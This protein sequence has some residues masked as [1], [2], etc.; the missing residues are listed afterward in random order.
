[1]RHAAQL[2]MF[3]TGNTMLRQAR[4]RRDNGMK[5]VAGHNETFLE[6]MRDV[7]RSICRTQGW[8]SAD[9]LRAWAEVNGIK[10][11]HHNAWGTVL[12]TM[13]FVPGEYITSEQPQGHANRIRRW[14]LKS[15]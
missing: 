5:Q 4:Q 7:A 13:E 1:M 6:T 11:N 14:T 3:D 9:H 15:A 2:D 8:V 10:P 12:T